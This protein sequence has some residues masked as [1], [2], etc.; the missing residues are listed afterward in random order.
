MVRDLALC[1]AWSFVFLR[2]EQSRSPAVRKRAGLRSVSSPSPQPSPRGE[3]EPYAALSPIRSA[4]TRRR[5]G[6]GVALE[7]GRG[8][9]WEYGIVFRQCFQGFL[10]SPA[11]SP[12]VP[13]GERGKT[14]RRLLP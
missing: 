13:R 1:L 4:S 11:L 10:L 9:P 8:V 12:L 7:R 14:R 5:A 3:G 6:G 2:S